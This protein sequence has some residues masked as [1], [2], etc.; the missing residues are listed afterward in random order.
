MA[1]VI[2]HEGLHLWL[3]TPY[4]QGGQ[5]FANMSPGAEETFIR[6]VVEG[7][8]IA[9]GVPQTV[10]NGRSGSGF[11][12]NKEPFTVN[13]AGIEADVRS[14]PNYSWSTGG[15]GGSSGG[16]GGSPNSARILNQQI[17]EFP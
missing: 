1:A 17:I 13:W 2:F 7:W 15:G 9:S 6:G 8:A 16:G 10:A 11:W 4:A 14:N 12:G 3:H 5:V